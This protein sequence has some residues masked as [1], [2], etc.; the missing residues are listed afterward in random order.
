MAST[1]K[2]FLI[3]Q[4]FQVSEPADIF[5]SFQCHLYLLKEGNF[6]VIKF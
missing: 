1:L 3:Q 2:E 5:L 4:G 6:S